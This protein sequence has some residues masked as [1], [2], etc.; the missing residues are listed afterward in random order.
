MVNGRLKIGAPNNVVA[1]RSVP[2]TG[3]RKIRAVGTAQM[4]LCPP[5]DL[6]AASSACGVSISREAPWLAISTSVTASRVGDQVARADIAGERHQFVEEALD[7]NTG[8]P[9]LP[10]LVGTTIDR[11]DPG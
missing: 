11:L 7:H 3:G 5:Y 6:R 1:K 9:R 2:T 10:F 8:L 4:R